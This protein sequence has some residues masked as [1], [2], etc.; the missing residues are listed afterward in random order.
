M[1]TIYKY[2]ADFCKTRLPRNAHILS[3]GFQEGMLY[4]WA[5]VDT[6]EPLEEVVFKKFGTGWDIEHYVDDT[7]VFL[8]TV[9]EDSFV[10][11][12]FYNKG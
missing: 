10:W 11:H 7:D 8:A 6:T 3:A 1:I 12:V 2:Y 4:C 9:F 5:K